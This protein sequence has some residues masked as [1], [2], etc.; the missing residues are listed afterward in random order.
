MP[1]NYNRT[2]IQDWK[3]PHSCFCT[4]SNDHKLVCSPAQFCST[5]FLYRMNLLKKNTNPNAVI[6]EGLRACNDQLLE[7]EAPQNQG[8]N[9]QEQTNVT[10]VWSPPNR[11]RLKFNCDGAYKQNQNTALVGFLIRDHKGVVE[12]R[13]KSIPALSSLHPEALSIR[14]AFLMAVA[15]K[16]SNCG[17]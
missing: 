11:N 17:R 8:S 15:G 5:M 16:R 14:E 9:A 13:T 2:L 1:F 3:L 10:E 12:E 7:L 4:Q 6:Y